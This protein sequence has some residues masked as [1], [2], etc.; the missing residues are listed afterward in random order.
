MTPTIALKCRLDHS[1]KQ[2]AVARHWNV[3]R[4]RIGTSCN[5]PI[6]GIL[7][8]HS[9]PQQDE[10]ED[11]AAQLLL[12]MSNIVSKEIKNNAHAFDDEGDTLFSED[13]S[14]S[15]VHA[16][17]NH[18]NLLLTPR[19]RTPSPTQS[20]SNAFNWTRARTVS[21]DSPHHAGLLTPRSTQ[22]LPEHEK[23]S[24]LSL[25]DP[26]LVSPSPRTRSRPI[27]R[28][29]LKLA[30]KA[31]RERL[32]M[33]KMPQLPPVSADITEYKERALQAEA[34]KGLALKTIG[35]KKFS[36]KNYPELEAF[37]IANREEYLRH[38]ALNYTTQQKAF[39]NKLTE[40]LLELAAEH[41]YVFDEAEFSFVTVRDRIRCYFKSY[42]QSAKK[43]GITVG[44]AARKAGLLSEDDLRVEDAGHIIV[45]ENI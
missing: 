31:K 32:K 3:A 18:E 45:P 26:A 9:S 36:W 23:V 42:V 21:I 15:S 19:E 17:A 22:E 34:E 16:T 10:N 38:S 6:G 37:L 20:D 33:P 29:S 27:R 28:A 41:G 7:S 30:Q 13:D 40:Q 44:Y 4:D 12:S 39:N 14:S 11:D 8:L 2:D 5:F 24:H 35:R 43:R 1:L 25:G